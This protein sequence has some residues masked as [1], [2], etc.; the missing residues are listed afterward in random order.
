MVTIRPR[1]KARSWSSKQRLA[2]S[3]I[4]PLDIATAQ[5]MLAKASPKLAAL[6]R[7]PKVGKV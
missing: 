4:G 5:R 7:A 2:L 1:G 3:R 6:T